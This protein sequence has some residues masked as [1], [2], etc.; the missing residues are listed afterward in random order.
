MLAGLLVGVLERVLPRIP[1]ALVGPLSEAGGTLAYTLSP[2]ARAAVR[3]NQLVVA[4]TRR[5]RVRRTFVNQLRNSI[6]TFRL[7]RITRE[8]LLRSVE[9]IGWPAFVAAQERGRGVIMCSAHFGPVVLCGQIFL[10][11]GLPVTLPVEKETNEI[12]RAVNRARRAH[13]LTFVDLDSAFGMHRVLRRGGILGFLADRP[14]TGVGER[15]EFFGRLA[16]LPSAPVAFALRTGAALVPG[17][18]HRARGRLVAHFEPALTLVRT[19]DHATD[20]RA[21]VREFARVMELH[22]ARAP[23]E[24]AAF[25]PLWD[26]GG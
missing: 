6:D 12:G 13:G 2:G 1:A 8:Q 18:A 14:V 17:F 15:V 4:P 16:L 19:G 25:Q 11:H 22:I 5:P 20:V 9:V 24:W 3:R 23:E 10:A 26:T 7:L 21:G